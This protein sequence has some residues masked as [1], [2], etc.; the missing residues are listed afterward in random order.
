M[1]VTTGKSQIEHFTSAFSPLRPFRRQQPRVA[2]DDG[3]FSFN[4]NGLPPSELPQRR[5]HLVGGDLF[6]LHLPSFIL[7]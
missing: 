5:R 4:D 1:G 3:H 6:D 2:D 7:N